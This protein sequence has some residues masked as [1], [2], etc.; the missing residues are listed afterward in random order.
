MKKT[1]LFSLLL[2][3]GLPALAQIEKGTVMLGG[4]LDGSS[5]QT[6]S[7]AAWIASSSQRGFT[8]SPNVSYFV[9]KGLA[10]GAVTSYGRNWSRQ[11]GLATTVYG[12][13]DDS[14]I[15]S[16]SYT[17]G[18]AVQ[19]YL[20]LGDKLAVY[21][22]TS[23]AWG[24]SRSVQ[25]YTATDSD[26]TPVV[27]KYRSNANW[28]VFSAGPGLAYFLNRHVALLGGVTYRHNRSVQK[29]FGTTQSATTTTDGA[30]LNIGAQVFLGRK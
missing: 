22:Q 30:Y 13:P 5:S 1:I 25:T 2:V 23:L 4:S 9:A 14:R 21:A 3:A 28:R 24:E 29:N 17:L 6:K 20:M 18:P 26:G 12:T 16:E 27:D 15:R 19:Y 10:L 8:A 11:K 7:Q